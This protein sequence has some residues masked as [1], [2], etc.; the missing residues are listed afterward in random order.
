MDYVVLQKSFGLHYKVHFGPKISEAMESGSEPM[1][2]TLHL[3]DKLNKFCEVLQYDLTI[4]W[5]SINAECIFNVKIRQRNLNYLK[6]L[7][8]CG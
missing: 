2:C 5:K 7:A 3:L 8:K 6:D 1:Q 4:R